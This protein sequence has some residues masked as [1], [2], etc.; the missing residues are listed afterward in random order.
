M[1]APEHILMAYVD[2]ELG[3]HQRRAVET[4]LSDDE[5]ARREAAMFR[6][7]GEMVRLAF[8]QPIWLAPPAAAMSTIAAAPALGFVRGMWHRLRGCMRLA[9]ATGG[10][11]A[12]V[13][14]ELATER[15]TP[16]EASE[17]SAASPSTSE[18]DATAV[19]AGE[20]LHPATD[21]ARPR[22]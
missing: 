18:R 9:L 1:I 22:R 16:T 10:A 21:S 2:G 19:R 11:A 20:E 4:W 3:R 14:A 17:M 5:A 12:I 7:T 8:E 6:L 15:G 13:L